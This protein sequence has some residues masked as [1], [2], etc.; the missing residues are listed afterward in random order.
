MPFTYV[1][2]SRMTG[3]FYTGATTNL[4][5]RIEQHNS[6]QSPSTKHRGPWD[7]VHQEEFVTLADALRRERFLKSGRGRD[8]LRRTLV[9][10]CAILKERARSSAG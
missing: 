6:D 10:K 7:L 8:E 4:E 3:R 5:V 9:A 1:L 2:R